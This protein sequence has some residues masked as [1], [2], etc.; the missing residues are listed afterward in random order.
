MRNKQGSTTRKMIRSR[1]APVEEGLS[2]F[3]STSD[4]NK[5]RRKLIARK[6]SKKLKLTA[7]QLFDFQM[8]KRTLYSTICVFLLLPVLLFLYKETHPTPVAPN[9]V[10][11]ELKR[12]HRYKTDHHVGWMDE[13]NLENSPDDASVTNE[14]NVVAALQQKRV[15]TASS[16]T[17]KT[18]HQATTTPTTNETDT[19]PTLDGRFGLRKQGD[20]TLVVPGKAREAD[21]SSDDP[22][23]TTKQTTTATTT[24]Y[25]NKHD[26]WL[27]LRQEQE[28]EEEPRW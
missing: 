21:V 17:T 6:P 10:S 12:K 27:L 7:E 1:T 9:S 8:P 28:E 19:R 2:V 23:T 16:T 11:P 13:Q 18:I 14:T 24:D 20:S 4:T 5:P 26:R 25:Q 3:I 22:T 15:P